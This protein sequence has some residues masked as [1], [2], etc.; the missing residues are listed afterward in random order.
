MNRISR[1]VS[2][3][4]FQYTLTLRTEKRMEQTSEKIKESIEA[5]NH[6][7]PHSSCDFLT[8]EQAHLKTGILRKRWKSKNYNRN[9]KTLV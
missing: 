3:E 5:Y 2:R 4:C 8:P 1:C 9:E 6:L 7:R